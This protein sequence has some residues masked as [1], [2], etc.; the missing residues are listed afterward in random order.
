[1]KSKAKVKGDFILIVVILLMG[2]GTLAYNRITATKQGDGTRVLLEVEG[3]VI[4]E[5]DL[6]VDMSPL[7]I[8]TRHGYNVVEIADGQVRVSEADCPDLLCVHT[9]WRRHA[10]Q[11]IVCLPHYFIVRI[12]GDEHDQDNL[13]GFTY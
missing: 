7:R 10:G 11:V 9:G 3:Q 6:S 13:D 8:E 5:F 1:M 12:V 4:N 2:L